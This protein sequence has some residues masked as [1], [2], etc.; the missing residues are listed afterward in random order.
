[1]NFFYNKKIT[2]QN[3]NKTKTSGEIWSKGATYIE[4]KKQPPTYS[5]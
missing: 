2:K 1:M 5:H 4:S 3:S